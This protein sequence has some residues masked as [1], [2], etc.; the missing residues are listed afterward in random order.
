MAGISDEELLILLGGISS[1]C[2][3]EA[4]ALMV[5][6]DKVTRSRCWVKPWRETRDSGGN[7]QFLL[8]EYN[9]FCDEEAYTSYLRMDQR[10]FTAILNFVRSDIE[11]SDTHLR[12]CIPVEE[13]LAAT[14]RFLATGETFKELA[15]NSKLSAPYLSS[16][17]IEVCSAI[18]TRMKGVFKGKVF[19]YLCDH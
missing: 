12:K 17:I 7:I 19:T 14:L 5:E 10:C 2:N 1:A 18:Y 11:R 6:A 15:E 3:Y 4:A 16:A 13:K 9:L 8:K